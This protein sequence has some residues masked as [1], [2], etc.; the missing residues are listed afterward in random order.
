MLIK[1]RRWFPAPFVCVYSASLLRL[2]SSATGGA[3]AT[4]PLQS[5]G[6][7]APPPFKRRL[8][9]AFQKAPSRGSGIP[10]P[11]VAEMGG[12]EEA[13]ETEQCERSEQCDD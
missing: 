11:P 10:P 4:E 9:E 12:V 7:A 6:A 5:S 8:R 2:A 13:G 1:G 3:S